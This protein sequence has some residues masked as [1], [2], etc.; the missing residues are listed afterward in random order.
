[1]DKPKSQTAKQLEALSKIAHKTGATL[2][3]QDTLDAIMSAVPELIS[4]SLTEISLWD[5]EKELLVP[6]A[7]RCSPDRILPL[8][9][10]YL[11]GKGYTG[12]VVEHKK[13]L[14]VADIAKRT[15]IQP[16]LL[17]GEQPFQSYI[18]LPLIAGKALIGTLVLAHDEA[19]AFDR[20]DMTLVE[21]L[22]GYAAAAIHKASLFEQLSHHHQELSALY[23]IAETVNR[24]PDLEALMRK[25]L[26]R[27]IEVTK[28]HGGAI[29]LAR[30]SGG[31]FGAGN[32]P[33]AFRGVCPPGRAFPA[34]PRNRRMGRA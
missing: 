9:H 6:R 19:G 31:K 11:L 4:C 34:F 5:K 14:W 27:V 24:P 7:L 28:A 29:R 18:G 1:V 12:W 32:P 13:P 22:A 30:P 8:G 16:D 10:T 26:D 25:A 17:P 15:D 2:D 20:S 33:G 23:S 3:P 21:T